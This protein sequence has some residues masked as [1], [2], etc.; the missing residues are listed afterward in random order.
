MRKLQCVVGSLALTVFAAASYAEVIKFVDDKG[1][2]SFVDDVG[3][4]PAKYRKPII[5]DEEQ[6]A[7]QVID[8]S[9]PQR[10][11]AGG[12]DMV[13]ICYRKTIEK[14]EFDRHDLGDF[15]A[16]RGYNYRTL[17]VYRNPENLWQCAELYC[18]IYIKDMNDKGYK[19][20]NVPNC[21]SRMSGFMGTGEPLPMTFVG[22]R[23]YQGSSL[24][25]TKTIDKYFHV[26]PATKW[27]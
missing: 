5:R 3:K 21:L 25:L 13:Y 10:G 11:G 14:G 18:K 19:D 2:I 16:A 4:V 7:V 20:Y 22:G 9:S 27:E 15:L 26:N 12:D 1:T 17:D 23:F 6:N 24:E 8:G